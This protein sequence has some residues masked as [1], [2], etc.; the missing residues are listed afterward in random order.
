MLA[1]IHMISVALATFGIIVLVGWLVEHEI[2][3]WKR[4]RRKRRR[5]GR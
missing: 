4:D 2:K 1:A 5:Q 3:S